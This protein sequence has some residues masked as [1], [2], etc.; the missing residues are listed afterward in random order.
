MLYDFQ[1]VDIMTPYYLVS[2]KHRKSGF[3]FD[4]RGRVLELIE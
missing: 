2:R 4:K 1:V 3:D